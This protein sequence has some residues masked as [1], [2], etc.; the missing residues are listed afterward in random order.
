MIRIRP[1]G[2]ADAEAV[3][4]VLIRSIRELCHADHRGD[5]EIIARWT[6]NK[7]PESVARWI[8][9]PRC[10]V[11]LAE[12]EG[13][14][15]GASSFSDGGRILLNYVDP[16]H[17]FCG[18]SRAMLHHMEHA[19]ARRGVGRAVLGSTETAHRFYLS[20]GWRDAGPPEIVFGMAE[21][22]MEKALAP[23]P[24]PPG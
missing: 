22:P 4:R 23:A 16:A 5:P 14:P 1:A 2:P 10:P 18:V 9:D 11:L 15:A 7:A 12:R 8:A 24:A 13:A 6:A 3:S 19:L 21:Y 20:A 17:R